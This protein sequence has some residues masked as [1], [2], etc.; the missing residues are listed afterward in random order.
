MEPSSK[1]SS[2]P[3]SSIASNDN[4]QN[5]TQ[6]GD[7]T[8]VQSPP[9]AAA[10]NTSDSSTSSPSPS[11]LTLTLSANKTPGCT[12]KKS[13]CLKLYCQC[14]AASALCD[15][16]ICK[17]ESCKN[18][19]SRE[20]DIKRARSNV[21]Y[22]NPRAFEG[23][24]IENKAA[25]QVASN[26][27]NGNGNSIAPNSMNAGGR[28][29]QPFTQMAN[30]KFKV[31]V[32]R[33]LCLCVFQPLCLFFIHKSIYGMRHVSFGMSTDNSQ[34]FEPTYCKGN[35]YQHQ[36]L[37]QRFTMHGHGHGPHPTHNQSA[38]AAPPRNY[39]PRSFVPPQNFQRPHSNSH[40][41]LPKPMPSGPY[42]QV[43]AQTRDFTLDSNDMHG[44]HSGMNMNSKPVLSHKSGC[45]C[46]KSFCMKKYCE[47]F[48]NGAKCGSNCRCINCKNQQP[49]N[50]NPGNEGSEFMAQSALMGMAMS[51]NYL[52]DKRV[53]VGVGGTMKMNTN[54]NVNVNGGI[55]PRAPQTQHQPRY[56]LPASSSSSSR[57]FPTQSLVSA[58][59]SQEPRRF[60]SADGSGGTGPGPD[61]GNSRN[62]Y[63][64]GHSSTSTSNFPP[65]T[66]NKISIAANDSSK[67]GFHR[68]GKS[69]G[70][71][72]LS[73]AASSD[74]MAIMAALAMTELA[75]GA[76]AN[77]TNTALTEEKKRA[78]DDTTGYNN[79]MDAFKRQRRLVSTSD[80]SVI[81]TMVSKSSSTLSTSP[82]NSTASDHSSER[83]DENAHPGNRSFPLQMA[84]NAPLQVKY[85]GGRAKGVSKSPAS[86]SRNRLPKSL[87]FRK[88]CSNCGKARSD[89]GELGFGNKCI[90]KECGKC[91][92][93]VQCHERAGVRMGFYCSLT[94]KDSSLVKPGMA[95]KYNKFINDL[96]AMAKLKK[97]LSISQN[98]KIENASRIDV[99][100]V[101]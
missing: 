33:N 21:L 16:D 1:D 82:T 11:A 51:R 65:A 50:G 45:K 99:D 25:K 32:R 29:I 62:G 37:L 43:Q 64:P 96:A 53:G 30:G 91:G 49:G 20:K 71:A 41:H 36:S 35:Q 93:G 97:D 12:C 28:P 42:A 23:K 8:K 67:D 7:D 38:F 63:A 56:Q 77:I 44:D 100:T 2:A 9:A 66:S 86:L 92:A 17:C 84:V 59:P 95:A 19:V 6:R 79:H 13:K 69:S 61:V 10:I 70:I 78:R 52:L 101:Q 74:R 81:S 75:E 14:F 90:F 18:E 60:V 5:Q 4:L 54:A 73:N 46:R 27:D 39:D 31:Q 83:T 98:Q 68:N 22:R 15:A 48:Q 87:T 58:F 55:Y 88:I 89:H 76:V 57:Q 85:K 47:C 3:S 26:V 80:E 34:L 94:E 40:F 24:F 72:A